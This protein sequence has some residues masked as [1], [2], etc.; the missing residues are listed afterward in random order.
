MDAL[1]ANLKLAWHQDLHTVT[2][3]ILALHRKLQE[4]ELLQSSIQQ[5]IADMKSLLGI[6]KAY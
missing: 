6:Q 5:R 1:D 4:P 2:S 3:N